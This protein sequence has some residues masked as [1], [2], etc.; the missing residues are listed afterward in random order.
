ML[1]TKPVTCKHCQ[2]VNMH[3]SFQCSTIRKPIASKSVKTLAAEKN[4]EK[5]PVQRKPIN[6]VS[7][8]RKKENSQYAKLCTGF[9][10]LN[11]KCMA[12][13]PGCTVITADVHHLYSGSNRSKYYLVMSTW[14]TVCSNCHHLIHDVLGKEELI[15]LGLKKVETP[16]DSVLIANQ[17]FI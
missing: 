15:Q 6:K 14:I 13:L 8:K 4:G 3:H 11:P 9:K 1:Q 16:E 2:A 17:N 12:K 7:N 5:K 10:I